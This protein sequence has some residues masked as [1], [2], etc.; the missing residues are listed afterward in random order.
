MAEATKTENTEA[1]AAAFPPIERQAGHGRRVAVVVVHGM[2]Q[3]ISFET[4]DAVATGLIGAANRS[5]GKTPPPVVRRVQLG[6]KEMAR[7]EL[8]LQAPQRETPV[9]IYEGYWAPLTEGAIGI[10]AVIAFL[11]RAGINGVK[12]SMKPAARWIFGREL[13]LLPPVRTLMFLLVALAFVS[14]LVLLNAAVV[15]VGAARGLFTAVGAWLTPG[16]LSDLT[17]VLSVVVDVMIAFAAALLAS[18]FLIARAAFRFISVALFAAAVFATIMAGAAIPFLAV[19]HSVSRLALFPIALSDGT[20]SFLVA[21]LALFAAVGALAL[22]KT[23]AR[24]LAR[25]PSA[26]S[27]LVAA[28]FI[29]LL[30]AVGYEIGFFLRK[31]NA[32]PGGR[33]DFLARWA[34]TWAALVAISAYVRGLLVQYVGDVAI[35][36]QPQALDRF[37]ELREQ[38]KKLLRETT[39]PI[40]A[41]RDETGNFLYQ[42]VYWVGHSLGSV[43]AYDALNGLLRQDALASE[44]LAV[45]QRTKLLLTFGS[46]LDKTA[47]LFAMQ[48]KHHGTDLRERLA[49]SVQPLIW[50]EAFRD[51]PWINL[52]S[53]WDIVSGELEYYDSPMATKARP[54]ENRADPKAKTF[55]WSH[56]E[57][58]RNPLLF[59]ILHSELTR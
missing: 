39:Y 25:K 1:A 3:Q 30:A 4:L 54:V 10:K 35:Y 47:F 37:H 45:R 27:V 56:V 42:G 57:Y 29:V 41:A 6:D 13:T 51:F 40:Y 12:T 16:L 33:P 14:A 15:A 48:R 49:A 50:D 55:L 31:N 26:L 8:A 24:G 53:R 59:D 7:V 5:S 11:W 52:Y 22:F 36:I 46:P 18:K 44:T 28:L 23:I 38:I 21:L 58:W 32:L 20:A 34:V 43:I 19:Y 2:G 9:D 17:F